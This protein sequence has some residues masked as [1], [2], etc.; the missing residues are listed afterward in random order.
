VWDYRAL[1]LGNDPRIALCQRDIRILPRAIAAFREAANAG[2]HG[3]MAVAVAHHFDTEVSPDLL[4]GPFSL[5]CAPGSGS[6][7][8]ILT[9]TLR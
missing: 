8:P 7:G 5:F 9:L 4:K 6:R 1:L 2:S 3:F